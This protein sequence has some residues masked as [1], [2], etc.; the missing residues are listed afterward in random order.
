[1]RK[2]ME[3]DSSCPVGFCISTVNDTALKYVGSAV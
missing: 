3:A 2:Q 1:M